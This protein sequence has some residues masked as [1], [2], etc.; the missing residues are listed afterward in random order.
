[1]RGQ[2]KHQQPAMGV[3]GRMLPQLTFDA[4]DVSRDVLHEPSGKCAL[5]IKMGG[6]AQTEAIAGAMARIGN[7]ADCPSP[8]MRTARRLMQST[9]RAC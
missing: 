4:L 1:M 6:K 7:A 8:Q 9:S 3:S 5:R 2:S